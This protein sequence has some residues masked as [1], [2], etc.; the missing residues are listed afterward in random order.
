MR[1]VVLD[2][3]LF[4]SS[5]LIKEGLPAQALDAWRD[6]R[7]LLVSSPAIISELQATLSYPR[8]R[9]K[10]AIT[11]PDVAGL[12]A[13]LESDALL[14]SGDAPVSGA[15]PEDPVSGAVPE[16]P[17]SGAVPEDPADERVLA[18]A[19]DAGADLIVSGDRHL[20][21]LD[22]FQGIP[23]L[24]VRAFLERLEEEERSAESG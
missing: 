6:R 24:T 12:C 7:Y 21:D 8:I 17:V 2:T 19:L 10:Y 15:V 22:S 14:I 20:L 16:D 1:K 23:T 13:L 3:N 9:R 5:L 18:C 4:V 11:D